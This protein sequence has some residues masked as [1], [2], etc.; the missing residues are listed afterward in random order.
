MSAHLLTLYTRTSLHAGS[1]I[2]VD[3]VD[4]PF[5]RERVTQFPVIPANTLARVLRE[6]GRLHFGEGGEEKTRELFGEDRAFS[7]D[8]SQAGRVASRAGAVQVLEAKLL[9][10]PVRALKGCF[11][12]LT[13]PA[14][15]HRFHR[16]TRR[17]AATDVPVVAPDRALVGGRSDLVREDKIFVEDFRLQAER[18]PAEAHR[19]VVA[20]L[21]PL[22]DDSLW[23]SKLATR[24]A[25]VND[26]DFQ[27][28]VTT[29]MEIV[30]HAAFDPAATRSE[31][32]ARPKRR[33]F[34]QEYVPSETLFYSV[35]TLLPSGAGSEAGPGADLLSLLDAN[36]ALQIGS[37]AATGHGFC[38]VKHEPIA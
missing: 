28:V 24:L 10:F 12:W 19:A 18:E 25:I 27:H 8:A 38:A 3:V 17:L 9:A 36:P 35:L 13:C 15:L 14:V 7:Y 37:D 20:A 33:L 1:G 4:L 21:R 26:E 22:S 31:P 34:S 11:A 2:S 6:A 32:G 16:D 5:H 23:Q 29:C 30:Q